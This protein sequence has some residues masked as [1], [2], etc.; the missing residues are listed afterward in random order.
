MPASVEET[1]EPL[2]PPQLR[3]RLNIFEDGVLEFDQPGGN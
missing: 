2:Q 1:I 3:E